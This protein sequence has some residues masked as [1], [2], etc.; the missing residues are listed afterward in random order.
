LARPEHD[1]RHP[2]HVTLRVDRR[3]PSLRKQTVFLNVRR[4]IG[5]A[6]RDSFR[7]V[8]FSVQ[9]DHVH[10]LVEVDGKICLSRG[11]SGLSIRVARAVNRVLGRRGR[12]WSDRFH[13]RALRSPREV[14][15]AIVYVVMNFK[16]HLPSEMS[17]DDRSSAY[18]LDGWKAP[19]PLAPPVGWNL[20][21]TIPVRP[22]RTWLARTAW[23]RYGLID[24]RERPTIEK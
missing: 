22:P 4:A 23:R 14:R 12:V 20:A 11:A 15:H 17:I 10:L 9:A 6:S 7:V 5:R 8:H 1:R 24:E 21:E 13:A 3:L 19:P 18:W 2:V 16:K